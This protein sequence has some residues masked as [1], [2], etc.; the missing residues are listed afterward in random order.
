MARTLYRLS[1]A[2]VSSV[3]KPGMYADGGS[4]YLQV[5]RN[6][7]RSWVF[8]FSRQER[9]R[10]MGLG[11]VRAVS[12]AKARDL[13]AGCRAQLSEGRDPIEARRAERQKSAADM[14]RAMTFR[15]AAAAYLQDHA[16]TWRNPKH[17][18]QW[19]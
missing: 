18:G 17:R 14:A 10:D 16:P 1:A 5:S 3:R 12:L 11:S 9:A 13:A 7:G 8:R 2:R 6:G 4:L 15:Q 19:F